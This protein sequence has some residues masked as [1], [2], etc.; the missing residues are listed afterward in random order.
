MVKKNLKFFWA[1]KIPN[2]GVNSQC[3]QKQMPKDKASKNICHLNICSLG[4]KICDLEMVLNE[5]KVD[6]MCISEHWL[7]EPEVPSCTVDGY[8]C[9]AIYCRKINVNGGTA[10]YVRNGLKCQVLN[11]NDI[12]IEKI[13]EAVAL[14]F[15]GFAVV[16]VYRTPEDNLTQF[17]E[18]LDICLERVAEKRKY[19]FICGDINID[20]L[21]NSKPAQKLVDLLEQH[22]MYT[23]TVEPTRISGNSKTAIDHIM[24]NVP[25][26]MIKSKCCV[27]VGI[28][29]HNM[30]SVSLETKS[31]IQTYNY[32]RVFN[33]KKLLQFNAEL[34]KCDWSTVYSANAVD[35]KFSIFHTQFLKLYNSVFPIRKLKERDGEEKKWVTKGIKNTSK[36]YR[37]LCIQMKNSSNDADLK[38]YYQ[39]YKKIYRKVIKCAKK[40]SLKSEVESAKNMSKTVWNIINRNMGKKKVNAENIALLPEG[41]NN[42]CKD[43]TTIANIFNEHYC[44]IA[45]KLQ[46]P[47]VGQGTMPQNRVPFSMFLT[48]VTRE[49]ITAA[50]SNLKNKK[51]S[52]YDDICDE[53]VKKCSL[54]IMEPL[55]HIVQSSFSDGVYPKTLKISKVIPLYKKGEATD[56]Q[57]FRPV[58]NI[59]VFAKIIEFIMDKKVR[60][61]FYKFNLFSES[62]FGFLKGLSTSDAI[63]N[64]I[65]T[66]YEALE[67]RSY[68]AGIFFDMSKA[69]DLVN[70]DILLDKLEAHGV[71]GNVLAWFKSYLSDRVQF[72]EISYNDG[73]ETKKYYSS[74]LAII[75]GVIQGSILGPLL[76]IIFINDLSSYIES[77]HLVN[78]ADDSNIQ[79]NAKSIEELE[80]KLHVANQEMK[81]W[82]T[83]NNLH[84]ND[85][86]SNIVQFRS[87]EKVKVITNTIYDNLLVSNAKFLGIYIDQHLRWHDHIVY[88][89]KKLNCTIYGIKRIRQLTDEET[90]L[91]AYHGMFHSRI[92]YGTLI[93][94]NSTQSQDIFILQKKAIRAIM[95]LSSRSTCRNAFRKLNVMTLATLYIF[96]LLKFVKLNKTKFSLNE[97][98]HQYNTRQK[99]HIHVQCT[100]LHLS[101]NDTFYKGAIF[102]NILPSNIKELPYKKFVAV[103]KE[104]LTKCSYYDIEEY[105]N[106]GINSVNL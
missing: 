16:C 76:F 5:Y 99:D 15:E 29:D 32:S 71:R 38:A 69:F 73:K 52:G 75:C 10:I 78:F 87:N 62:Q 101:E 82:C 91:K 28:S 81:N 85:D 80:Y 54:P 41:Q 27:E 36:N 49:D 51:C 25:D 6:V 42:I 8:Y 56:V 45:Q 106:S 83:I 77:G 102:Y 74:L 89:K 33:E 43:P 90:A 72:I 23:T 22:G 84:L 88:L 92:S 9:G 7:S 55:L 64:F 40:L 63:V 35:D 3:K 105:L 53:I 18:N 94:G 48:P 61:Y 14:L 47:N 39:N 13:F 30:Q 68:V 70:H 103:I 37:A 65:H 31:K 11:I 59:S 34:E 93:W 97:N 19:F 66:I 21:S 1:H 58:A 104:K 96:E 98:V 57:N 46:G 100:S 67:E 86:K 50:I 60:E 44:S 26:N 4:N 2:N 79:I 95:K 12:V 20:S 24:T 17:F